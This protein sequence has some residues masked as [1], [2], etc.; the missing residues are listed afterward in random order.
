MIIP[1]SENSCYHNC[2]RK[3][4]KIENFLEEDDVN[5]SW[6]ETRRLQ[7]AYWSRQVNICGLWYEIAT[8][9]DVELTFLVANKNQIICDDQIIKA[10]QSKLIKAQ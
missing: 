5:M 10:K 1:P 7:S 8:W 9:A 6:T 2:Q 4:F 3:S